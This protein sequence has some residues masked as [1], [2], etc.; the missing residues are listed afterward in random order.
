M[1]RIPLLRF[2]LNRDALQN[3]ELKKCK[4]DSREKETQNDVIRSLVC[5]DTTGA[6]TA[7]RSN[8]HSTERNIPPMTL[9]SLIMISFT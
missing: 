5:P 3:K 1:K 6:S 2:Y 7:C 4:L 9:Y 8:L